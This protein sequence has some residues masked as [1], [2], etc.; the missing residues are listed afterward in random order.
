[1]TGR[2]SSHVTL[3]VR[4][5]LSVIVSPTNIRVYSSAHELLSNL[6]SVVNRMSEVSL[7][8]GERLGRVPSLL[9]QE[10]WT[11]QQRAWH[12]DWTQRQIFIAFEEVRWRVQKGR[13]EFGGT[14]ESCSSCR[15]TTLS[16]G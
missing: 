10:Y 11:L 13:A 8:Q 15:R 3:S 14:E 1:M 6:S 5:A 12:D 7:N 9:L 2:G 16:C 4:G